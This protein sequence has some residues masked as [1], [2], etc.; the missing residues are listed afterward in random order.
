MEHDPG[1]EECPSELDW[2]L[3]PKVNQARNQAEGGQGVQDAE[4]R[5]E[6]GANNRC[7]PV[8]HH[9]FTLHYGSSIHFSGLQLSGQVTV[10]YI[11]SSLDDTC[12]VQTPTTHGKLE[13]DWKVSGWGNERRAAT[14]FIL[15]VSHGIQRRCG[16]TTAAPWIMKRT[17]RRQCTIL[18]EAKGRF[19]LSPRRF[20]S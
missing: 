3:S 18:A 14:G 20:V 6:L 19:P 2:N 5:R 10:S 11:I 17:L 16:S 1:G 9:P 15:G 8:R 12:R 7:F 13:G 4:K